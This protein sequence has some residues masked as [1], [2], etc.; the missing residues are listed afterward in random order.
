MTKQNLTD[1]TILLDKSSSMASSAEKTRS[2]INEFIKG[3]QDTQGECNISLVSFS[4]DDRYDKEWLKTVWEGMNIKEIRELSREN[5]QPSGNTALYD[6]T[7]L[8]IE[9]TGKRFSRMREDERPSKVLFVI[10]TDGEENSSRKYTLPRLRETIQE[11][12]NKYSWNFLFLG[13]DFS[14]KEQTEALGLD[15]DRSYDF[16]KVDLVKSY[17]GLSRAVSNYRVGSAQKLSAGFSKQVKTYAS[18]E[19]N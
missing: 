14:T 4:A 7:G 18:Q 10:M 13:A 6:A 9:R 11:Q 3:Q 5:Y 8:I 12:E 19:S 16:G 17:K 15:A 1:I 2:A